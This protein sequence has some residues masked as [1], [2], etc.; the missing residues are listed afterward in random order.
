M[1]IRHSRRN[2]VER[3]QE[4]RD[5]LL[6]Y[7]DQW[8]GRNRSQV[9][10]AED[11]FRRSNA[12]ALNALLDGV[13]QL[14]AP[15]ELKLCRSLQSALRLLHHPVQA[16]ILARSI[17]A[18]ARLSAQLDESAGL[19]ALTQSSDIDFL[20][21]L[22]RQAPVS[23][24]TEENDALREARLRGL[25]LREQILTA[26]GGVWSAEEVG[27]QLRISR[28]AVERRRQRGQL[29]ALPI[30]AKAYV[31]PAW[32]FVEGGIL[33][34]FVTVLSSF[35]LPGPWTRAAFFLS[36]NSLLSNQRPLDVLRQGHL[37]LVKQA[38]A[39]YGEQVAA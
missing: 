17:E 21:E 20:I 24:S 22:L 35:T 5:L 6:E 25:K 9:D 2:L 39:S 18:M 12:E 19:V 14:T 11:D 31:Y 34:G 15:V 28:Q 8:I 16:A 29:L 13:G 7:L 33:P 26:E 38:A 30:G 3:P 4:K 27:Q 23:Q 1:S 37:E 36:S 10:I 32:Q